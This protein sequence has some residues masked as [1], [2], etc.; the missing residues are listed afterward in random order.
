MGDYAS[1]GV[2]GAG[3]GLGIAGTALGLL[4]N[5]G[6]FGGIIG[7]NDNSFRQHGAMHEISELQA[8]VASLTSEK[9]A[10]QV[11]KDVYAQS[12]TDNR[13]LREETLAA[14]NPLIEEAHKNAVNIARLEEQMKCCCDKQELREQIVIGKINEVALTTNG[15]FNS[16]E[17]TLDCMQQGI[18][19]NTYRLNQI[20]EEHIPL[21]KVCPEPMPRYNSWEMP[22]EGTKASK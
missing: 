20:T 19:R 15:R 13:F 14:I 8:K 6:L 22:K 18:N 5:N 10:D 9:Y 12:R 16:L 21:S 2:A 11:G 4:N 1:K 7:G 3:L 17:Q